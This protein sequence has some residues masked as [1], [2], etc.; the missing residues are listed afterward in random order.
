MAGGYGYVARGAYYLY[1]G[2]TSCCQGLHH[3]DQRAGDEGQMHQ[4]LIYAG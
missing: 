3:P 4:G 2:L 1:L